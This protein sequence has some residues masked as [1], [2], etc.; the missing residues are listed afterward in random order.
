MSEQ[1]PVVTVIIP[2][3]NSSGTLKLSLQTVLWQDYRNSEVWVIGD[4]C[5]DDSEA[6][7]SSFGDRRVHWLNLPLNSGGPS[8]P[9]NEGLSRAQGQYVAYLGHDDLWFP[10]HLSALL[11]CI[12]QG[13]ADFVYSLGLALGPK[14]VVGPFTLVERDE[15]RR[16]GISPSNWLHRRDL[17]DAV[18]PWSAE[19]DLPHDR[20]FLG[21][22]QEADVRFAYQLRLSVLRFPAALWRMYALTAN[23]PQAP[24]VEAMSHDANELCLELLTDLATTISLRGGGHRRPAERWPLGLLRWAAR[25]YGR[26]RWPLTHLRRWLWRRRAGLG[27]R[28]QHGQGGG[29]G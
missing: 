22:V 29:A 17:V 23:Y 14:G 16:G 7:V 3:Y 27:G 25:V 15:E 13:D 11:G 9:R 12:S 28:R 19:T 2:T 5:T 6:A 10:W 26:D 20:E 21:R 1:Q 24:Y 18:G 4:G 8:V